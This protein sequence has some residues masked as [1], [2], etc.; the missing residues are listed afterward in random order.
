MSDAGRMLLPSCEET[1]L[2]EV[3][4]L[5]DPVVNMAS[6]DLV[7]E[8]VALWT[9]D[10]AG[11]ALALMSSVPDDDLHRCFMP[12]WGIRA[13]GASG[14]LFRIAFCFR[15]HGARLWGP[16]VPAEQQGLQGFASQSRAALELLRRFREAS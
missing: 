1:E 10:E 12:G 3:V 15:C 13:H 9:A 4:R 6:A 7:G 11:E 8:D 2:I 16:G 14:L 5:T